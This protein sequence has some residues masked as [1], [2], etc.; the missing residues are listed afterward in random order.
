MTYFTDDHEEIVCLD[1]D[2]VLAQGPFG[3]TVRWEFPVLC[4]PY[5]HRVVRRLI[6]FAATEAP[7][8]NSEDDEWYEAIASGRPVWA[9][10]P[11]KGSFEPI[12]LPV[13]FFEEDDLHPHITVPITES[14]SS[15]E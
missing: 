1:C 11:V 15:N 8:F 5:N 12:R 9:V 13:T 2:V 7:Y 6:P 10:T 14:T 3:F 4:F